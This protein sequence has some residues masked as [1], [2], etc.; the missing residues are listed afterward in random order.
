MI[1]IGYPADK[2]DV[3]RHKNDRADIASIVHKEKFYYKYF[4]K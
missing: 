2:V 1:P 3:D 4:K